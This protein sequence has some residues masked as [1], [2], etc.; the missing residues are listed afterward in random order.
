RQAIGATLPNWLREAGY[1]TE[2][3][4][5]YAGEIF[6]RTPLGFSHVDA[7]RFDI[8]A[9]IGQRGLQVHPNILP[10]AATAIGRRLFP[11]LTASP[12]WS[13][14]SALAEHALARLAK[15]S[16]RPSF[17]TIFFSAPHFPS[18]APDPYYRRFTNPKYQG[19]FRFEKPPLSTAAV[20]P[21]DV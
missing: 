21:E 12:E 4:S 17:L 6:S 18:A 2:I 10:Y 19:P 14:P 20:T 1:Q 7:P 3:V 9:I 5:D 8:E 16:S 15:L 13:D 11:A